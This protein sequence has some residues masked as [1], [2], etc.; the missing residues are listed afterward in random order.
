M[1]PCREPLD[2]ACDPTPTRLRRPTT[3]TDAWERRPVSWESIVV[4]EFAH[5][6]S[7]GRITEHADGWVHR[8]DFPRLRTAGDGGRAS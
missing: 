3:E 6:S 2:A 7:C 4:A 8:D 5:R 1:T